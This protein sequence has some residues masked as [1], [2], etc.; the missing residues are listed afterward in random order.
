MLLNL[1]R[2][3]SFLEKHVKNK[4]C[5]AK[6]VSNTLNN[7]NKRI[8]KLGKKVKTEILGIGPNDRI[9]SSARP[10]RNEKRNG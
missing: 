9:P 4:S 7:I 1:G 10:S 8:D 5:D 6:F 2:P 3:L